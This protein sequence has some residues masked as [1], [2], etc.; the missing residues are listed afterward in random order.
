MVRWFGNNLHYE[1]D[2]L[3]TELAGVPLK[4]PLGIG[5]ALNKNGDTTDAFE[6]LGFGLVYVGSVRKSPHMGNPRPWMVRYENDES[7]G[8]S[9]GLPSKGV[10]YVAKKLDHNTFKGPLVG[11]AVG[12]S[13][14]DVVHVCSVLE[15]KVSILEI[16]SS[17]PTAVHKR[18]FE[19]DQDL[20]DAL[21]S[22]AKSATAKPLFLK[23]SPYDVGSTIERDRLLNIIET[24]SRNGVGITASN[25]KRISEP[26]LP[27]GYAG[28]SGKPLIRNTKSMIRE[29]SSY[30]NDSIPLIA[31]GG[32]GTGEDAFE[33]IS[34]GAGAVVIVTSFIYNGPGIIYDICRGLSEL[35]KARGFKSV[36][37]LRGYGLP[38]LTVRA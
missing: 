28:L 37:E 7:L 24:C 19:E 30:S 31:T 6:F 21:L 32:V 29:I 25:T 27:S 9:M 14:E 38:S 2:I 15:N 33:L 20:L 3:N 5:P 12:D 1:D 16:D 4:N 22:T 26:R 10:N 23:I 36:G 13:I 35:L 17:C 18:R 34:E 11:S 8:N